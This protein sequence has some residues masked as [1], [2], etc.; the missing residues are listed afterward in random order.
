M[1]LVFRIKSEESVGRAVNNLDRYL[2][3]GVLEQYMEFLYVLECLLP[4]YFTGI[5]Q[6]Y[7]GR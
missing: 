4:Q 2:V 3:V 1:V 5:Q 7:I 6:L